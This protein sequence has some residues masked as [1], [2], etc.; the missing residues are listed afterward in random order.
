MP[1][2]APPVPAHPA[3]SPGESLVIA[4]V[5]PSRARAAILE[6]GLRAVEGA[7]VHGPDKGTRLS[8]AGEAGRG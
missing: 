5:D 4:V 2:R 8:T 3:P 1:D 7:R 6:E